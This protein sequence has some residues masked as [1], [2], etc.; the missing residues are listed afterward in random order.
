MGF[1]PERITFMTMGRLQTLLDVSFGSVFVITL[2]T[3]I[4]QAGNFVRN[5]T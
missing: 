1:S 3:M 5:G 4:D 2:Q